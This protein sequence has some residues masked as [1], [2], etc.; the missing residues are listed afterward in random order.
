MSSLLPIQAQHAK[1]VGVA[2]ADFAKLYLYMGLTGTFARP[3]SGLLCQIKKIKALFVLQMAVVILGIIFLLL[4]V[5]SSYALMTVFVLLFG[6]ADGVLVTS[7]NI[8]VLNC[9]SNPIKKTS[10]YGIFMLFMSIVF[11]VGPPLSG[12]CMF[13][14]LPIKLCLASHPMKIIQNLIFFCGN[15]KLSF[16]NV[17]SS[18]GLFRFQIVQYSCGLFRFQILVDESS[19]GLFRFLI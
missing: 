12:N 10:G 18:Y 2:E 14:F 13:S 9:F 4:P 8:C 17:E 16:P 7:T 5:L 3:G 15:Q 1:D 11:L 6:I 19:Y